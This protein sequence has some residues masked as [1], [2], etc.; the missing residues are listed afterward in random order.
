[1]TAAKRRVNAIFFC[2]L[3]LGFVL[4]YALSGFQFWVSISG[5]LL[6]YLLYGALTYWAQWR[7]AKKNEQ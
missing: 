7:K 3:F 5:C 1:M 6:G 2:L 4:I